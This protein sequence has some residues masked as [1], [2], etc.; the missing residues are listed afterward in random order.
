MQ[1]IPGVHMKVIFYCFII[2]TL[3]S[4]LS[5]GPLEEGDI[6]EIHEKLV[7]VCPWHH[8]DFDLETGE[9]STGLKVS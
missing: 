4:I 2:S 6:E 8:F 1:S 7:V 3:S 5:G 9:S